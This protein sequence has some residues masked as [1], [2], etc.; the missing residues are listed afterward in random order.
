MYQVTQY[1]HTHTSH[2]LFATKVHTQREKKKKKKWV[3]VWGNA[4]A[5][6][7]KLGNFTTSE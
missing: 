5:S 6:R 2:M 4:N 3:R 1:I 7:Q